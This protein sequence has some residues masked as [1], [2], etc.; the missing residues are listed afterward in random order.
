MEQVRLFGSP[1]PHLL[2]AAE[3]ASFH[4]GNIYRA[5][6]DNAALW[7]EASLERLTQEFPKGLVDDADLYL[8]LAECVANAAHHGQAALFAVHTRARHGVVLISF[9]QNPAL[10]ADAADLLE[11]L[12]GAPLPDLLED[13][14]GGYGFPILLRLARHIT[15]SPDRAQLR[16]WF[17]QA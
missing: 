3:R 2:Q 5:A 13:G 8:S 16:M 1:A 15:L 11:Q 7:E 10:P 4:S 6:F 12:R 17:R 9:Y 14:P